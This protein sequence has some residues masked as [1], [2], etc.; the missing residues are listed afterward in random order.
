MYSPWRAYFPALRQEVVYLDTAASSQLPANSIQAITDY[1][2]QGHGN[3][4]RGMHIF[5][6]QANELYHQC[7]VAIAEY[8]HAGLANVVLTKSATESINLVANTFLKSLKPGELI[9]TTELEHHANLLPWQR[10]CDETGAELRVLPLL[11]SGE[12]DDSQ[13]PQWLDSNCRL[14]AFSQSSNVL[15]TS[16]PVKKWVALARE[17]GV[18]TLIDGAQAI[19]H[20]PIDFADLDCDFYAFS[21]H[22]LYAS[23]GIGVLLAKEVNQLAPLL[24]GGGI[25]DEVTSDTY[26]LMTGP[27]RL[28][29]GSPNMVGVVSLLATLEFLASISFEAI[30]LHESELTQYAVRQLSQL[31]GVELLPRM[32]S[33]YPV[34]SLVDKQHHS[35]DIISLLNMNNICI[36]AGNHCAQPLMKALG[37]SHCLRVSIG[38]YNDKSDIDTL[39]SAWQEAQLILA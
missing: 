5:S 19:A 6:E 25:V 14:F 3:A 29:A 37:L 10:I 36:R 15:A 27:Q 21:S 12:V 17:A 13:L 20:E 23:T 9:I 28:E 34:I 2:I 38:M 22:K 4:H 31:D 8:C 24:L 30:Q 32:K 18:K 33:D 1:L 39:I 35:H 16:I 11:A 7:K 26:T